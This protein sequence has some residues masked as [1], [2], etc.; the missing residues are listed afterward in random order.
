MNIY[1]IKYIYNKLC[2][3]ERVNSVLLLFFLKARRQRALYVHFIYCVC[4]N[5]FLRQRQTVKEKFVAL[6]VNQVILFERPELKFYGNIVID[7]Q[8]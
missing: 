2:I 5:F 6:C 8:A 1:V 7:F 4:A 3:R